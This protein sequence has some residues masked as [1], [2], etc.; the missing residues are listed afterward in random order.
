MGV[1]VTQLSTVEP[2]NLAEFNIWKDADV[3]QGLNPS[4]DP[5]HLDNPQWKYV[6]VFV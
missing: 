3:L 5:L 1:R 6:A 2:T 4:V